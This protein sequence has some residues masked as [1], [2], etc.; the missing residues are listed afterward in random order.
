MYSIQF[1]K[2]QFSFNMIERNISIQNE[3]NQSKPKFCYTEL[4]FLFRNDIK[5]PFARYLTLV[6]IEQEI[7]YLRD[8]SV[9]QQEREQ[10]DEDRYIMEAQHRVTNY[11]VDCG[12][13]YR[14]RQLAHHLRQ[15]V[16]REPI[17]SW[18]TF[19]VDHLALR[20]NWKNVVIARYF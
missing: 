19:L 10:R 14:Q 17:G 12:Q 11:M 16:G 9:E 6:A 2:F 5:W 15:V 7:A 1:N 4:K 3:V 13:R 8:Y 18:H 20:G